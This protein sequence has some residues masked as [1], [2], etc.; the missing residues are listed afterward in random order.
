[1][2]KRTKAGGRPARA[3]PRKALKPKRGSAPKALSHRRAVPAHKTEVA[4]LTR[5]LND[6]LKRET[7]TS[8]VLEIISSSPGNLQQIFATMLEKAVRICD[9]KFGTMYLCDEGKLRLIAALNVPNAFEEVRG[10]GPFTPAPDGI[11]DKVIKTGTTVHLPD[12]AATKPYAERH[13]WVVEAVDLGG[14]RTVVAVP[15][16]KGNELIGIVNIHRREVRPFTDKQIALVKNFAAQAVIAIEN[17]RLLNEL[18]QRTADLS[19]RT[20]DLAESLEQQTATS[21]RHFSVSA[22]IA[23]R[24]SRAISTACSAGFSTGTGSLKM[25]GWGE[26]AVG[27]NAS[28]AR[29]R[30]WFRHRHSAW[31]RYIGD[32]RFRG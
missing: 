28:S 20:T 17:A 25:L 12:L 5:E 23:S 27:C 31:L 19:Q 3:R 7:A 14:I 11:L 10:A 2:R 1:M 29:A 13:P 21:E 16:F 30:H 6:S 8:E 26:L 22:P 32:H 15:M 4:R 18:R 24:I 9:A